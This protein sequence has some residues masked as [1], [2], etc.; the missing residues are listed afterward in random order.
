MKFRDLWRE[1][2]LLTGFTVLTAL[3]SAPVPAQRVLSLDDCRSL[4]V[5]NNKELRIEGQKQ[6]MARDKLRE[7]DINFFPKVSLQ[8]A[9]F[10]MEKPIKIVDWDALPFHLGAF[11]PPRVRSLTSVE[12]NNVWMGSAIGIQP[13]FM[14]GK[15]IAGHRMASGAVTL[16]GYM[17]EIKRTEVEL[18]VEEAYWQVVSLKS[19]EQLLTRLV[20]LLDDAVDDVDA[21]IRE[22]VATKADGLTIRVKRSEAEQKLLQVQNGLYLSRML[23]ARQCGLGLDS[24][25]EVA[26]E[27]NLDQPRIESRSILPLDSAEIASRIELRSEVRSLRLADTIFINKERMEMAEMLPKVFLAGG[28]ATSKPNLFSAPRSSFD[29]SWAVSLVM[30]IPITGI[31]SG[32]TKMKQA[33]TERVIKQFELAD[34]R[35]KIGLQMRQAQLNQQEAEKQLAAAKLN[36]QRADENLRYAQLGYKEGVI[37]LLNLTEAQ[38]A[39]ALAHDNLIDAWIAVRMAETKIKHIIPQAA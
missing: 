3:S 35:E 9:Y 13:I 39:W 7:V 12:L 38:T 31:V 34:A 14:G 19:K 27:L 28:W 18:Q 6:E 37:P 4:A 22:G 2:K 24:G 20:K 26:D 11:I 29:G 1:V 21:A 17:T 30:Q 23:L 33:H 5:R 32:Y 16:T 8:G 15:I 36:L 10:D 25:F